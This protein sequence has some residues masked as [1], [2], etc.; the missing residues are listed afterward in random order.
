MLRFQWWRGRIN[1]QLVVHYDHPYIFSDRQ[2][3]IC[4]KALRW[5]LKLI[6]VF[7]FVCVSITA[8]GVFLVIDDIQ[9]KKRTQEPA[10]CETPSDVGQPRFHLDSLI[11][12]GNMLKRCVTTTYWSRVGK[13]NM[14]IRSNDISDDVAAYFPVGMPYDQATIVIRGAGFDFIT[15]PKGTKWG[16]CIVG[17]RAVRRAFLSR[18]DAF[19]YVCP[20]DGLDTT[21]GSGK[22]VASI[23]IFPI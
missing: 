7:V 16:A 23:F 17:V 5:T 10:V 6:F 15:E 22:V 3:E 21:S 8:I 18:V 13:R 20:K 1:P 9:F 19:I 4:V 2:K 11:Q 12:R 14:R